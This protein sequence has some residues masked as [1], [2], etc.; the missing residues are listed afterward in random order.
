MATSELFDWNFEKCAIADAPTGRNENTIRYIERL[1]D[2]G[3]PLSRSLGDSVY[4]MLTTTTGT[5][6]MHHSANAPQVS[7]I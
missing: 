3:Q 5:R 6:T 4:L 7:T 2:A 1:I